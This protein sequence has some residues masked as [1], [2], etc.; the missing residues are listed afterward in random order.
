MPFPFA[1]PRDASHKLRII[2]LAQLSITALTIVATFLT[3]VVP[4]KHKGFTFG[5]LYYLI[6]TS[7]TT[8]FLVY[9]EQVNAARGTLTKDKYVKYQLFKIIAAVGLT[10]VAFVASSATPSGPEDVHRPGEQGWWINGVK[11]NKWQGYIMKI[12]FFNWY[13]ILA[14]SVH[15]Y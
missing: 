10:I 6:F 13:V 11:V 5:F 9:K 2:Q 3:A 4:S 7:I 15:N 12:N 14:R 8:T 1:L